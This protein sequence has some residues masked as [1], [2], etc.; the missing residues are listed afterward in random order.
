MSGFD[1]LGNLVQD[2]GDVAT[3]PA[4]FGAALWLLAGVFAVSGV[5]KLRQP[6]LAAM[7][8][9]DFGVVRRPRPI[10]GTALGALEAALA[11]GLA[12]STAGGTGG[13]AAAAGVAAVVLWAFVFLIVRSLR[14]GE[15]FECFCFGRG[16][17]SLSVRTALRTGALA[18][19]ATFVAFGVAGS[20]PL[21]PA[22]M[23]S[24]AVAGLGVLS[25]CALAARAPDLAR[26]N[27]DPF[28]R[29]VESVRR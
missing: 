9:A 17:A 14:A 15:R 26:W 6:A 4:F 10:H 22:S 25:V 2:A 23:A 27:D 8:I 21:D 29:N 12:A 7:A 19:L 18:V 11:L 5:A 13:N 1:V 3:E 16:D 20:A 28:E 24:Y